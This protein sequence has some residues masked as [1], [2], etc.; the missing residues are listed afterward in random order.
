[1]KVKVLVAQWCPTL[2][3]PMNCSMPDSL[4]TDFSRQEYWGG[5]P[6][7][8]PGD[9][10]TQGSN[11][12][13]LHCGQILYHLSYLVITVHGYTLTGRQEM[14]P[15]QYINNFLQAELPNHLYTSGINAKIQRKTTE[16]E[17]L[18]ISSRKLEYQRNI[19]CKD[20]LN[21]GQK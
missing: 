10:P 4:S 12:G 6:F 7:P 5:L 8:T 13:L 2:C 19:S 3:D 15:T 14:S 17:R 21:K 1:M 9:L 16:W 18:E 20:G 11:S